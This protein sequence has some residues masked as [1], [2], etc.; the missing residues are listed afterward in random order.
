MIGLAPMIA[1]ASA[2]LDAA[3]RLG[4][5]PASVILAAVALAL[6]VVVGALAREV[7]KLHDAIHAAD[8]THATELRDLTSTRAVELRDLATTHAT[9]LRSLAAAHA[10]EL[11]RQSEEHAAARAADHEKSVAE[12]R[13]SHTQVVE[14]LDRLSD[15]ARALTTAAE[16]MTDARDTFR[17][18]TIP[19]TGTGPRRG[20]R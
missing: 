8:R 6:V 11:R 9:E 18:S 4:H 16:A 19:P 14:R 17:D 13:E 2:T 10:A 20:G 12:L 3:D 15:A 5:A 1:Q 7:V